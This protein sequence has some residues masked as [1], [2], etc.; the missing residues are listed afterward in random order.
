[1][2]V[3]YNVSFISLCIVQDGGLAPVAA[4][5]VEEFRETRASATATAQGLILLEM[6][7]K[8]VCI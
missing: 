3:I 2:C 1:L 8:Q 4:K 5:T 6:T 7:A